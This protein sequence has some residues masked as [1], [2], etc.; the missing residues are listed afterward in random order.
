M[1]CEADALSNAIALRR[2]FDARACAAPFIDPSLRDH[3]NVSYGHIW[4]P[5]YSF[6]A[7]YVA[8]GRCSAYYIPQAIRTPSAP[9]TLPPLR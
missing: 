9:P 1:P 6:H 3:D 5:I 2:R 4:N 8:R 7:Q